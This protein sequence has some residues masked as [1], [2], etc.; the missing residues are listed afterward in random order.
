MQLDQQFSLSNGSRKNKIN[1]EVYE[2]KQ[3]HSSVSEYY[4]RLKCL[5][6]ELEGMNE[7]PKISVI[8]EDIAE[9]L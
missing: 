8:I 1:K 5:W 2:I 9:F 7:L 6:S 3:N 4:T